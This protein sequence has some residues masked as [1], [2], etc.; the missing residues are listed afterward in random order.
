MVESIINFE[1]DQTESLTQVNDAK[2]LSDQ[3]LKL[4][5]LEDKIALTEATLKK[6]Q[7]QADVLSYEYF[8]CLQ[9][10]TLRTWSIYGSILKWASRSELRKALCI[11]LASMRLRGTEI[12]ERPAVAED[13]SISEN[14]MKSLSYSEVL[15]EAFSRTWNFREMGQPEWDVEDEK[16][17]PDYEYEAFSEQ[18]ATIS[19][20]SDS[21]WNEVLALLKKKT[22]FSG[23]GYSITP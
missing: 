1:D 3:V 15:S 10:K 16:R 18:L 22:S 2:S 5:D 21:Y 19:I 4:R 23:I 9:N 20:K 14:W 7:E 11:H 17:R 12:H 13:K 8:D 6:L